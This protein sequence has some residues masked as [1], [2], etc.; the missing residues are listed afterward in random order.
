MV[1]VAVEKALGPTK[2]AVGSG[3]PDTPAGQKCHVLR[4][5]LAP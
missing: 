4:K 1:E 3:L 2:R 5:G